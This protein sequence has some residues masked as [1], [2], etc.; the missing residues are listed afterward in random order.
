MTIAESTL[1]QSQNSIADIAA[2]SNTGTGLS[3]KANSN[4]S[5][6]GASSLDKNFDMF[7]KLL[8]T[9]LK[10]QDPTNPMD[11][12]KFT[13]QL[14]QYSGIEQQIQTNQNL[15]NMIGQ[16]SANS[17]MS[18]LG[19]MNTEVTAGGATTELKAGAATWTLH[20]PSTSTLTG[21]LTIRNDKSEVVATQD[22]TLNPGDNA[23]NWNGK[24]K[25]GVALP[26]GDYTISVD[27]KDA[28]GG[29]VNVS[30]L[31]KG[32][33]TGIDFS[34]ASPILLVGTKRLRISDIT[35]IH[36]PTSASN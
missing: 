23:F 9:Q 28:T 22:Y 3:A 35:S 7:L 25:N 34:G 13:Q 33:V 24:D 11:A 29:V 4:L 1:A 26:E 5:S 2:N 36:T 15:T 18:V 20:S 10:T 12:D 32:L 14:V 31:V 8:T 16:L 30:M 6:L 17:M 21:H 27:A 19:F